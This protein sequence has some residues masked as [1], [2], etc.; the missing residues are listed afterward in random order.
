MSDMFALKTV[1]LTPDIGMALKNFRIENKVTAKSIT[2]KFEKAP[3]YVSKLENG[4]IK[5]IDGEL[6]IQ[7][8]NF[9]SGSDDGLLLFLNRLSQSYRDFDT[10][11]KIIVMNIDDLLLDHPVTTNFV[12]EISNYL[13]SKGLTV[14]QLVDGINANEDISKMEGFNSFPEN[15]WYS[16]THDI[17]NVVIKLNIPLSY[18]EDLLNEKITTI[19]SVIA[20]AILYSLYK[21][22]KEEKAHFMAYS[23]L[24]LHHLLST[25]RISRGDEGGNEKRYKLADLEPDTADAFNNVASKLKLV[26]AVT[27]EYG[28]KRIKQISDNINEDL[29]FSFAYMSID[30]VELEK[31]DKKIKQQFLDEVRALAEK[32][33]KEDTGIDL[34]E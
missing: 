31:K 23:K 28:A 25:R 14:N 32:Y 19:H 6:L 7:I 24:H 5:K 34:Y 17:D 16:P 11:S 22:G 29:S 3:S 15:I 10:E 20:E 18:I 9:I 8:C 12:T 21:L 4:D 30:I 26:T 2:E 33:S 27:K 1:P 13:T